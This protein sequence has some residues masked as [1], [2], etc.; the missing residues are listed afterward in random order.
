M[1]ADDVLDI[2]IK[3]G[4]LIDGTGAPARP[5]DLGIRDGRIVAI[6]EVSEEAHKTIDAQGRVVS[7]GFIDV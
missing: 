6:G 7:P 3:G 5:G 2:L 4:T 1:E